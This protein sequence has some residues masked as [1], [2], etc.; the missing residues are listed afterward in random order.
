MRKECDKM[1]ELKP[2]ADFIDQHMAP[3]LHTVIERDSIIPNVIYMV[4]IPMTEEHWT[5]YNRF[6]AYFRFPL[7][8]HQMLAGGRQD[9]DHIA[10]SND[11]ALPP[12]VK[13]ANNMLTYGTISGMDLQAILRE[14]VKA[15]FHE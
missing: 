1:L 12:T 6:L 15:N 13:E 2:L 10:G 7:A 8:F 5:M 14:L 11:P 9:F 4:S 3:Q